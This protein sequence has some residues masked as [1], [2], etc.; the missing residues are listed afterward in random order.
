MPLRVLMEPDQLERPPVLQPAAEPHRALTELR[1]IDAARDRE[2]GMRVHV[3][4]ATVLIDPIDDADMAVDVIDHAAGM[5]ASR[6]RRR[7]IEVRLHAVMVGRVGAIGAGKHRADH[8]ADRAW[9][10]DAVAAIEDVVARD[11]MIGGF[12]EAQI[13]RAAHSVDIGKRQTVLPGVIGAQKI[14]PL[15]TIDIDV[16]EALIG[17]AIWVG[18]I[19]QT[20][21]RRAAVAGADGGDELAEALLVFRR[22]MILENAPRSGRLRRRHAQA[23]DQPRQHPCTHGLTVPAARREVKLMRFLWS[24]RFAALL[25]PRTSRRRRGQRYAP[26][27]DL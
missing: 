27:H 12:A 8:S 13:A 10:V 26:D 17:L 3:V 7:G 25:N 15:G 6:L 1:A 21:F 16:E 18:H 22:P 19:A 14:R 9:C 4:D 5:D 2:I 11:G 20:A 24:G 23:K